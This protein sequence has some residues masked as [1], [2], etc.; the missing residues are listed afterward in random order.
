MLP[1]T[2]TVR[3]TRGGAESRQTLDVLPD[4]RVEIEMT[5]RIT[6]Y[7]ALKRARELNVPSTELQRATNSV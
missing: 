6:K 7:Q 4:P 5:D 2:Y 1:G 3:I